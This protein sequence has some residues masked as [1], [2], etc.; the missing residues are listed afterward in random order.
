MSSAQLR[1]GQLNHVPR[2]IIALHRTLIGYP[3]SRT[4]RYLHE[5]I[6][7]MVD[8]LTDLCNYL[9]FS[10][11]TD[12]FGLSNCFKFENPV[13]PPSDKGKIHRPL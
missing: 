3:S 9:H 2:Y 12:M 4:L 7:Y 10:G 6:P 1:N 11:V 5:T 13:V 8:H